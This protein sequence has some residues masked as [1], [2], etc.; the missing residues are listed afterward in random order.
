[1]SVALTVG[2]LYAV[3]HFVL[4][5]RMQDEIMSIMSQVGQPEMAWSTI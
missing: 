3:Y 1:M 4:R 2:A 5:Q